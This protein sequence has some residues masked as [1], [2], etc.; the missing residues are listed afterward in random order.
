MVNV[1]SMAAVVPVA[2]IAPYN[3]S[4]HGVLALSETL[5]GELAGA[6][7]PIGVTVVM[8][9]RVPTRLGRPAGAPEPDV[10][11]PAAGELAPREVGE[12]VARA[13]RRDQL[14]LFTHP[15]RLDEVRARFARIAGD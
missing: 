14:Y 6:G 7:A 11:V 3:V 1:A 2:G 10:A 13:V 8:P 9:G 15:E 5:H 12:R 4:K